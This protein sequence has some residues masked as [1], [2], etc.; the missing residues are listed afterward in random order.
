MEE[1]TI[2][3]HL[4]E[5][6]LAVYSFAINTVQVHLFRHTFLGDGYDYPLMLHFIGAFP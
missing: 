3:I 6:A 2:D 1:D 4:E 5:W